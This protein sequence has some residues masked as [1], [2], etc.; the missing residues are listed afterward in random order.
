M[1]KLTNPRHHKHEHLHIKNM[2]NLCKNAHISFI[3]KQDQID[4]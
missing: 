2:G 3:L 1:L 4:Q